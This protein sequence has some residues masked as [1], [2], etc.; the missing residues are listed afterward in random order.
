ME[1]LVTLE[2]FCKIFKINRGTFYIW[3]KNNIIK[4]VIKIG[5]RVYLTKSELERIQNENIKE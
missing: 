4:K 5:R 3:Q 1:E 2:E